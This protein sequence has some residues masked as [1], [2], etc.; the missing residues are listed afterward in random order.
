MGSVVLRFFNV[1]GARQGMNEYSGVIRRFI[2][3]SKQGLPLVIYG[4]G[5]QTRD[6]VNVRDVVEAVLTSMKS[7]KAVGEV[8][9]IGSGKHTSISELAEAILDLTD[10]KLGILHE[11]S[12]VGDIKDSYADISKAKK[13]LNYEP[14]VPLR[15]GLRELLEENTAAT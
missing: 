1:Y 6:F 11:K 7:S 12:R 3:F 15:D 2:E 4:D 5:S 9:N 13:L 14:L 10:S 8:F